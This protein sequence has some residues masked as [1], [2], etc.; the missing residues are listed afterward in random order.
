ML[1]P[2]VLRRKADFD[3]LYKK[4]RSVGDKYV[5]IFCRENGTPINRTAFL[6]SKKVG[7]SVARN[8][9]RRLMKESVRLSRENI[10]NG[11]DLIFIARSTING[12]KCGEVRRSIES[13]LRRLGVMK[14][15]K[16]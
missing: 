11:F 8:R 13:G 7:N 15:R 3:A 9:A 14:S 10:G 16:I 4:G 2:D 12:K 1:R 6:A 5:V